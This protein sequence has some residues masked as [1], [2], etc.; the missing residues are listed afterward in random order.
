M[1]IFRQ[2]APAEPIIRSVGLGLAGGYRIAEH[3]HSWGQ[4]L[5][6]AR[7][8]MS[9]EA[10]TRRWVVPAHR[11]V[12]LPAGT[13]HAIEMLSAVA[14]RTLYVRREFADGV[15]SACRVVG[16]SALLRELV[17]E[18]VRR[19]MLVGDDAAD[20][21]LSRVLLDQLACAP[22]VR[23][24]LAMPSDARAR[25]VAM[26]VLGDVSCR[27]GLAVL[28]RGVGA[29]ARTL[30]RL[31]VN[32]TGLSFGRWRQQARLQHAIGLLSEGEPV[33]SVALAC[34]YESPSAFVSM[35][36]RSLGTTPGKYFDDEG[37]PSPD[38]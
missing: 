9:V 1:S 17:L 7:G 26:R 35:F 36:K 33:T 18:V 30:E 21:R 15:G 31:Y 14:M 11:G 29:S 37:K 34:G 5:Y 3:E 20:A 27:D 22:E 10:G 32:E 4:F 13:A 28:G 24:D 38:G 12:W 6:A 2:A 8:V 16:V 19:G 25:R 23:L